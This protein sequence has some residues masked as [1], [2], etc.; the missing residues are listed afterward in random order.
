MLLDLRCTAQSPA[1]HLGHPAYYQSRDVRRILLILSDAFFSR[2]HKEVLNDQTSA[3]FLEYHP[4]RII[5][6]PVRHYRSPRRLK[7]QAPG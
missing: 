3:G 2:V 5:E 4:D 7:Y 6:T 1:E